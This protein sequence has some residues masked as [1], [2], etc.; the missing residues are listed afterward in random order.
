MTK[1]TNEAIG[2]AGMLLSAA[3]VLFTFGIAPTSVAAKLGISNQSLLL[4]GGALMASGAGLIVWRIWALFRSR[5][6]PG[7]PKPIS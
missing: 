7:I 6:R 1:M 2:L 5:I 3:G 4:S